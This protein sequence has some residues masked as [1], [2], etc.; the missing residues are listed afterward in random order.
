MGL[1]DFVTCIYRIQIDQLNNK[2]SVIN[3]VDT[4]FLSN[5]TVGMFD[6]RTFF[7]DRPLVKPSMGI[8][9]RTNLHASFDYSG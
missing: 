2:L 7:R 1:A 3:R 5:F 6:A 8:P 9:T 4:S